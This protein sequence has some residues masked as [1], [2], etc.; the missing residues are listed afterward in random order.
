MKIVPTTVPVKT[1][2]QKRDLVDGVLY[3]DASD[4]IFFI[5]EGSAVFLRSLTA[6]CSDFE[7]FT[8]KDM[9]AISYP[10][11]VFH[12]SVTLSN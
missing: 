3:L 12:G 11:K 10:A 2:L 5:S 7:P 4:W 9:G 1:D 8:D 6:D